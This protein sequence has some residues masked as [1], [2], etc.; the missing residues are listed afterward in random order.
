MRTLITGAT[1]FIGQH[2]YRALCLDDRVDD[3][4][5]VSHQNLFQPWDGKVCDGIVRCDLRWEAEV[6]E[7]LLAYEPELI[8]HLA[9]DPLVR[10]DEENPLGVSHTN[11]LSTHH[12]LAYAPKGCRF[13]FAS[14]SV[15]YGQGGPPVYGLL[16]QSSVYG[17]TKLASEALTQAYS[18]LGRVK[19]ISL[20]FVANVG[21]GA[22]H[23][24]VPDFLRKLRSDNPFL[25]I[26]GTPPGSRK[27]YVH[28]SDTVD[29]IVKA[30]FSPFQ[31]SMDI[32]SDDSLDIAELAEIVMANSAI[33]KPQKWLGEAA[34]WAGDQKVVTSSNQE[35]RRL[36]GWEPRYPKSADAVGQA[37]KDICNVRKE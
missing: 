29:A 32:G 17:A 11:Y 13:V 28:V 25:E 33:R 9:A 3:I 2:L 18:D 24:V 21:K 26:L 15:V 12:L 22:T 36:L 19:G 37:V 4:L 30:A 6:K 14:S 31:G 8:F 27:P 34:N 7:L 10:Y 23:G 35:A 5:G 16:P 1:G 20:R